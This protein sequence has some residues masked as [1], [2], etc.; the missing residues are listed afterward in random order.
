MFAGMFGTTHLVSKTVALIRTDPLK[1]VPLYKA[2][3]KAF[4]LESSRYGLWH[5]FSS[6][7]L[8]LIPL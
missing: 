1:Y 2:N 5:S 8:A 3:P 6:D 7:S 4:L